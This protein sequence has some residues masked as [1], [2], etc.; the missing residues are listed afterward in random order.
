METRASH[1]LIGAFTLGIMVLAFLFVLWIGKLSLDREW[2]V[3]EIVFKEAVTGLTVGGAVQYNGIQ[4]GE[5]RK[6]L[7]APDD[8]GKVIARVRISHEIPVKTDTRAKLAITGL[9]GVAIVQLSGGSPKA[10]RLEPREGQIIPVIIADESAIAKLMSSS[11]DIVTSVNSLLLRLSQVLS[12]EN[13]EKAGAIIEHVEKVSAQLAAHDT[14]IGEAVVDLAAASKLLRTTLT[15]SQGLIARL[16]QLAR[17]ADQ[18][19]NSEGRAL[20]STA[21]A[22]LDSSR[23]L[24]DAADKV[25]Q[26]N[27][28]A[29]A[30]F[31]SQGLTQ[32]GPAITDLRAAIRT[33]RQLSDQLQNDPR[34]FLLGGEKPKE[35]P[36]R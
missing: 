24:A 23:K 36:A 1:V 3:Y 10:A 8:P 25:L 34:G 31:S 20:L 5:V 12:Q 26:Q 15:Q 19:L 9:T 2:D 7:L 11:E 28:G 22:A 16:D 17:H 6:L 18:T 35:I 27:Q 29:L 32:V 4:V 14:D 21:Q 30:S 33:L 13:L